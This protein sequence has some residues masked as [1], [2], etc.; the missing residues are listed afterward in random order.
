MEQRFDD[1][2][3]ASTEITLRNWQKHPWLLRLLGLLSRFL[4]YW[5]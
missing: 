5:L 1:D 4:R 2:I 3:R